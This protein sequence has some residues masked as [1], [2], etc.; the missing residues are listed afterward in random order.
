MNAGLIDAKLGAGLFKKRVAFP[1]KGKRG[2]WRT[3]LGFQAGEKAFFLYVFAKNNLENIDD[4][5]LKALKFLAKY[6]LALKP[7][8]IEKAL[9][10]GELEEM[11]ADE[12]EK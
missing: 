8:D 9:R 5:E 1:G 12:K 3:L 4:S 2:G 10:C 6:Y 7:D 11:K